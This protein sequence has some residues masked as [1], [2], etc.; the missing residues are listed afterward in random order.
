VSYTEGRLNLMSPH[1]FPLRDLR[2]RKALNYAVNKK[3]LFQYAFKGNAV[4]MK[5]VLNEKSGVDL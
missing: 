2:V 3:E 4:E 5:G 1:T